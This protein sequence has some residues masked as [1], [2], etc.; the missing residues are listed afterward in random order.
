[1]GI[2]YCVCYLSKKIYTVYHVYANSWFARRAQS[3]KRYVLRNLLSRAPKNCDQIRLV[4]RILDGVVLALLLVK[5]LDYLSVETGMAIGS[6]FAIGS[7]GTLIISLGSQEVAKGVV[8]GVE[9]AASD[10]FYEGDNVHFGD[11][12]QGYIVKMG[13]LRTKIRTYDSKMVDIPNTQ[14]GGQRAINIS[15]TPTCRIVTT[16]RFEYKDVQYLPPVMESIKEEISKSCPKLITDGKPFRVMISS[17]GD[18]HVEVSVNCSFD[19]PPTGEAFWAN[20]QQMFL[21][22]DR[23]VKK[24]NVEYYTFYM[25]T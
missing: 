9:M 1:M 5:I 18:C 25:P 11:G 7:T 21:A 16:L 3:F 20:R 14:L 4:D 8:S 6:I 12:T 19:L 22:I 10:R 17:F 23:S 13:Y 15:R 24:S 2:C